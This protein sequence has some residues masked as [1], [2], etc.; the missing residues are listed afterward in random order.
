MNLLKIINS[1]EFIRVKQILLTTEN[2]NTDEEN[3]TIMAFCI[4]GTHY[5]KIGDNQIQLSDDKKYKYYL[6]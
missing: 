2:G 5:T 1:D 6:R 3:Y 4:E